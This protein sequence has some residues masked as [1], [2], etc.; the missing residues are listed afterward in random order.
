[1]GYIQVIK[2]KKMVKLTPQQLRVSWTFPFG[3]LKVRRCTPS[4]GLSAGG[5]H[6]DVIVGLLELSLPLRLKTVRS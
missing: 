4:F 1:M 3:R 5:I 2:Q 6:F